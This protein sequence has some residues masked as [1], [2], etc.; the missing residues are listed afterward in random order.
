MPKLYS[1]GTPRQKKIKWDLMLGFAVVIIAASGYVIFRIYSEST[2]LQVDN[3]N[4]TPQ[5]KVI[6]ATTDTGYKVDEELFSL[7]LPG[8]WD[9][10]EEQGGHVEGQIYRYKALGV[11]D[12]GRYLEVYIN[13]MPEQRYLYMTHILPIS[14]MP[15]GIR[16]SFDDISD[17]C[18]KF[19]PIKE[20][21]IVGV[22][23][24]RWKEIEF[25][26]DVHR[27]RNI[28]GTASQKN[29][30]QVPLGS[31]SENQ[32]TFFFHYTDSGAKPNNTYLQD[33]IRSFQAK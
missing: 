1:V 17:L 10:W 25:D 21:Q 19:A 20:E 11:R 14:A 26:C 9:I 24:A 32:N 13:S 3:S 15:D 29:G 18:R 5:T 4:N 7:T 28:V 31:N 6:G 16:L 22:V 8:E 30:Y 2:T 12:N 27:Y 23:K 33:I